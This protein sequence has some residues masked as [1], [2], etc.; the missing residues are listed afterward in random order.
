[1]AKLF[2][3]VLKGKKNIFQSGASLAIVAAVDE[4]AAS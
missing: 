2:E 3:V 4:A 1:M